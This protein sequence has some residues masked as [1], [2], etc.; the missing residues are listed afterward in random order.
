LQEVDSKQG[1]LLVDRQMENGRILWNLINRDRKG[2]NTLRPALF[3]RKG[4]ESE[5]CRQP[6]ENKAHRG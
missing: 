4:R 3:P 2:M 6:R 5:T 1:V